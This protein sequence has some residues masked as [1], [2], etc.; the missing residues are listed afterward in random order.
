MAAVRRIKPDESHAQESYAQERAR[1]ADAQSRFF[2]E[3][4]EHHR[5]EAA[6]AETFAAVA[7]TATERE[8]HRQRAE[9]L[10]SLSR[11]DET[12]AREIN[13]GIGPHGALN[14]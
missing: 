13:R 2:R 9:H 6:R 14:A 11:H 4:A 1:T 10:A 3:Q 8:E 12:I 5:R 7:P